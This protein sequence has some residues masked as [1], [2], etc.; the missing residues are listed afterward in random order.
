[1]ETQEKSALICIDFINEIV[2][3][4]GKLCSPEYLASL[5]KNQ[6]LERT[7]KLQQKF[8]QANIPI[9][10]VR[11]AFSPSYWEWSSRTKLFAKVCQYQALQENTWGTEFAEQVK[12]LP[13]EKT[14]YKRRV[15]AFYE[16]DLHMTLQCRG[17]RKIYIAGVATDL[18]VATAARDAHDRDYEVVVVADC[19]AS[20]DYC[21]HEKA[22]HLL[23]KIADIKE[24]EDID[25]TIY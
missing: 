19:C 25:M 1:M 17:I 12:P 5:Q 21:D 10:H 15:S 13:D 2:S 11:V 14:I 16:T 7:H 6:V 3:K 18:A 4:G 24:L 23:Q 9:F 20:S 8:R 22:L